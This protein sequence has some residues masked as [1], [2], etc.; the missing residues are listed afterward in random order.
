MGE[1]SKTHKKKK[2]GHRHMVDDG[3]LADKKHERGSVYKMTEILAFNIRLPNMLVWC[4]ETFLLL[5]IDYRRNLGLLM[6]R[7]N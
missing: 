1:K 2:H 7:Q 5:Y 4:N 3:H 6:T